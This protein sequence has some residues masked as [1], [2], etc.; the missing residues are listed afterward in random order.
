[1]DEN[2]R[3]P[4]NE[5]LPRTTAVVCKRACDHKVHQAASFVQH[6][7]KQC[8]AF[9]PI[10]AAPVRVYFLVFQT[11]N[12]RKKQPRSITTR[13]RFFSSRRHA[14]AWRVLFAFSLTR[15]PSHVTALSVS[16]SR[17]PSHLSY[18]PPRVRVPRSDRI[19]SDRPPALLVRH[20][21]VL[22]F[23]SS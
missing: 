1:M 3:W 15:Y 8:G 16:L 17:V 11:Q 18:I 21:R 4:T 2:F 19:G 20:W 22:F 23:L 14:L 5:F 10:E 7:P 6:K 13:L 9:S 12:N